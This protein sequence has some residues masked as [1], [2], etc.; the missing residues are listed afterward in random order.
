ML[1]SM[2]IKINR[3]KDMLTSLL[4]GQVESQL[5]RHLDKELADPLYIQLDR[6]IYLF[7]QL[8]AQLYHPSYREIRRNL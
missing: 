6:N 1:G 2:R 4:L 3:N 7:R 8:M 5:S